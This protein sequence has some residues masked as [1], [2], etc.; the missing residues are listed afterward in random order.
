MARER[1]NVD[2]YT[3]QAGQMA[4]LAELLMRRCNVAVPIV[5]EGE[6]TFTFLTGRPNVTRIQVK[7]ANAEALKAEGRYAARVSVPLGQ[8]RSKAPTPLFYIFAIRLD[9][10]WA[11]FLLITRLQLKELNE[12]AGVGYVNERAGELQ[13]YLSFGPGTVVCSGQDLQRYRNAWHLLPVVQALAGSTGA[14]G[15]AGNSGGPPAPSPPP[16]G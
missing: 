12:E 9:D 6:D 7:T 16:T 1:S 2:T 11:D 5:D 10:R 8:L 15:A 14:G 4:V 13:L 3:G